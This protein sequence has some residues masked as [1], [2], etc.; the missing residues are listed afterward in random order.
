M[1]ASNSSVNFAL[2]S[3]AGIGA[4]PSPT[5]V[6]AG[7]LPAVFWFQPVS[8]TS[9]S[10]IGGIMNVAGTGATASTSITPA[11][12]NINRFRRTLNTSSAVAGNAAS[13]MTTYTRWFRGTNGGFDA[14]I[15][16]ATES[17]TTGHGAFVGFST[18]T[19][20]LTS[21]DTTTLTNC[22]GVGYSAADLSTGTWNLQYN[23][24]SGS[25]SRI[26]IPGMTR[27]TTDGYVLRISC[28]KG[29]ASNITVSISNLL[30][31]ATILTPTVITTDLPAADTLMSVGVH[32]HNGAIASSVIV[33][34]PSVYVTCDY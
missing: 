22:I 17:N 13:I 7:S 1:F 29:A 11:G 6:G 10:A 23:D 16:F 5:A 9:L 28:P 4:M 33:S 2:P 18:L 20:A 21:A 26:A 30:T 24:A 27:S 15:V 8:S 19:A 32:A 12:A 25:A 34:S 31:G 3:P 14:Q